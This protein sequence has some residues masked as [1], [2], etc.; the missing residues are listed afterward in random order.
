MHTKIGPECAV[1]FKQA[2][3][4]HFKDHVQCHIYLRD[5][6][7]GVRLGVQTHVNLMIGDGTGPT[8]AVYTITCWISACSM[9]Y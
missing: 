1:H 2:F 6:S 3:H 5:P 9:Q 8:F 7:Q 4:L